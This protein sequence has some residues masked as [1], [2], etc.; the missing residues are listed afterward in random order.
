MSTVDSKNLVPAAELEGEDADE[1]R[2]LRQMFEEAKAYL[3]GHAWCRS[4]A[5]SYFG[6]GIGGVVAAFLFRIVPVGDAD[7]WLWVVVGDLPTAYLV[8]D[9][10]AQPVDAL[11]IYCDVMQ[12]W[13]DAVSRGASTDDQFPIDVP[14]DAAHAE[15]L[16][17]RIELL[18][19]EVIPS[20]TAA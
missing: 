12:D 1:T 16:R 18:R 17:K 11:L 10:I 20:L 15:M 2:L 19:G 6:V 5:E 8:P 14:P 4:V 7:E 9:Q 3:L 13:V